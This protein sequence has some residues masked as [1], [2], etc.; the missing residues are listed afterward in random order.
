[1]PA[2][3]V[4]WWGRFGDPSHGP[5][6]VLADGGLLVADV[7]G[8]DKENLAAESDLFG[9]LKLPLDFLAGV[10]LHGP[11]DRDKRDRLLD[12][13]ARA[14]GDSDRLILDNDDELA[15]LIEGLDKGVVRIK[16]DVGRVDIVSSRVVAMIFNPALRQSH[17]QQGFRAWVGLSDGGRVLAKTLRIAG[18]A[19]E[20]TAL[21]GQTWKTPAN[22]L[23]ALQPLGG[24]AV[25]LS[26]LKPRECRHT[27]YLDLAWPYHEDRNATGG[28]LRCGGRLCLKGLGVHSAA[29][30]SYA[31]D[32]AHR[33]FQADVGI[34]DSTGG[35]GSVEF[36]IL[37]DGRQRWA[38]G[39]VRGG[40]P[41]LP[42]SIDIAG[43]KRLDLIVDYGERGDQLDRADWL[44]ARLLR[45]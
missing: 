33:R 4:A 23:V 40:D 19:A 44:G 5:L 37:V 16:T 14:E 9:A 2:A 38:S 7:A 35:R 29:R 1:M 21:A 18:N 31:L 28:L 13:I 22:A 45:D 26:D 11:A 6:V 42:V 12:R 41:P 27:P 39:P 17:P 43:G 3:E 32:P 10:V 25:Y 36:R 20:I 30:L 34:D 8:I 15:G 24:R